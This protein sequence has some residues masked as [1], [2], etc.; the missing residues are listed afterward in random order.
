MFNEL[1]RLLAADTSSAVMNTD[2]TLNKNNCVIFVKC[3]RKEA[4]NIIKLCISHGYCF[5]NDVNIPPGF[6]NNKPFKS[7]VI[8]LKTRVIKLYQFADVYPNPISA[9]YLE[10]DISS[11]MLYLMVR[12]DKPSVIGNPVSANDLLGSPVQDHDFTDDDTINLT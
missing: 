3:M 5:K 10:Y 4:E 7:I 9:N 1:K 2:G 8:N 11:D 12:V 6:N